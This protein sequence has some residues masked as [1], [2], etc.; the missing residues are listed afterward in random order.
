VFAKKNTEGFAMMR[1]LSVNVG[2]PREV[3]K[4]N[5]LVRTGIFK[6]PIPGRV[7]L[8]RLNLAGDAQADLSVHGGPDKAVYAYPIENYAYWREQ[9]PGRELPFGIF[10]ENLTLEGL[11]DDAV[12]IGDELRLGSARLVVTQPRL[13]CFKLGIRFGD[14][15]IVARFLASNRPGFYLAVLQEGEVG[16]G[17]LVD[18]VHEDDNRLTVTELFRVM[19]HDK[20][21]REVM[22]RALRVRHLADVL[23]KK[24]ESRL[25]DGKG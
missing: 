9:L 24:F 4:G 18:V 13:P 21:N 23:R 22:Q 3:A 19:I 16:A 25:S 17:D 1:I 12:H 10:G 15:E 2:L 14:P 6:A 11:R 7:L 8:R 20:S 5:D